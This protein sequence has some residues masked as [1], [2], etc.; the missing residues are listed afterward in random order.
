MAVCPSIYAMNKCGPSISF[1]INS[2]KSI[3]YCCDPLVFNLVLF[4]VNQWGI[5][6]LGYAAYLVLL[7]W[8]NLQ[9]R[10]HLFV[11]RSINFIA[12]QGF[13]WSKDILVF[14]SR[15]IHEVE[16]REVMY[17][18]DIFFLQVETST[19]YQLEQRHHDLL[20]KEYWGRDWLYLWLP[21]SESLASKLDGQRQQFSKPQFTKYL[22]FIVQII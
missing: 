15:F 12:L 6:L 19:V 13:C 9:F 8:W 10:L 3:L 5:I 11:G 4:F 16:I 7:L 21:Y 20:K 2:S 17:N 1:I 14:K 22:Q 18:I